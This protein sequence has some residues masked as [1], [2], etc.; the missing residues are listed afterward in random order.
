[1][2]CVGNCNPFF[3]KKFRENP[4]EQENKKKQTIK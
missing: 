2:S 1:M 3:K 4:Q